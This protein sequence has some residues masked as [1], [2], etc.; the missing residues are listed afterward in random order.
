[1][2]V[3]F[4]V[5]GAAS[6]FAVYIL[7]W[8]LLRLLVLI[9]LLPQRGNRSGFWRG[10]DR[11]DADLYDKHGRRIAGET[12]ATSSASS[13]APSE[14]FSGGGGGSGGGGASGSW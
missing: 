6:I 9:H 11:V 12:H 7:G 10:L 3:M 14:S 2:Y 5:A 8:Y 13:S 4:A 1:M